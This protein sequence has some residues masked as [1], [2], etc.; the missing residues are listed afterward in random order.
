MKRDSEETHCQL[1][2]RVVFSTG[3]ELN[4]FQYSYAWCLERH[5][6]QFY[7]VYDF[8]IFLD[9]AAEDSDARRK[10][11]RRKGVRLRSES[12]TA[13]TIDRMRAF[14]IPIILALYFNTSLIIGFAAVSTV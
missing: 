3:V 5:I 2:L 10:L 14:S 6:Y 11:V 12:H 4:I 13:S 9:N 1:L 7:V 8:T